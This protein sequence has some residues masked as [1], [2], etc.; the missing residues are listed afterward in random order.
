MFLLRIGSDK[1]MSKVCVTFPDKKDSLENVLA[2]FI[3]KTAL[4]LIKK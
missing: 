3:K 4:N 2:E 1:Q